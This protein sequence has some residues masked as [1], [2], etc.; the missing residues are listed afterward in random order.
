[1]RGHEPSY[2]HHPMQDIEP[3]PTHACSN[4]AAA[5]AKLFDMFVVKNHKKSPKGPAH[6]A[7]PLFRRFLALL[8]LMDPDRYFE[9]QTQTQV[10]TYLGITRAA[11]SRI[12]RELSAS[13]GLRNRWMKREGAIDVYRGRQERI[14]E[15]RRQEAETQLY[16]NVVY[17]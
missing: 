15:E 3:A 5:T 8:W 12:V 16:L 2:W 7:A 4:V 9:G 1:M 13:T 10:A 17:Q 14:W 6:D 11:F